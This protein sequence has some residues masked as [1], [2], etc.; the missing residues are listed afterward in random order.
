MAV[1]IK[2]YNQIL[3]EMI[4][5]IIADT[6]LNDVNAG[7]TLLTLMEAAAQVDFENN[8]SI[9]N[10]L[11]LL[12]IDAIS[13]N[14][15]DARAADFGLFRTP[16]QKATGFIDISDS[17]ITKI[18][19]G[20]YQVKPA[21]IAGST[22]LF[23]NDASQWAA[24]G[25][26]FIGRGTANF[27]GP[28]SYTSIVNSGSFFT[29][30]LASSLQKDH[31]ISET[32]ID[33][34]G[35][36]NRLISAGTI[37]QIPANNLNPVI[38]Y[39][40]VR[41]AIIPAGE[42]IV[43]DVEIV[44]I[45]AG[46][47]SNAGINTIVKF[48][49]VPFSGAT[50][51]NTTAL[52]NGTDVETDED[53]R[54]RVKSYSN[55][56]ARG[57]EAA[58][59]AAVIG[60]SDPDDGKQVAS[61]VITEP[62]KIGDPSILYIDDGGGFEPSFSG[63]SVD[64]LLNSANG[65]EE[66]LQL[67][68]FP[69]PRPQVLNT[70]DGPYELIDQMELRV[71]VDGVEEGII[72]TNDQF[73]NISAATLAETTIAINSQSTTFKATF[74]ENSN[75]ILL[76]PLDHAAETIQV[77]PIKTT[78]DPNLFANT[79]LKFPT[80]EFSYIR[81]YQNS[82]LL[83]EKERSATLLTNTYATW[84]IIADGHLIISV[85]NTPA[86]NRIFTEADFGGAPFAALT[87]DDWVSVINQKFAGLTAVSTSSGRVQLTSNKEGSDS[88]L[89]ILGG[90]LFD[91]LFA[92]QETISSGKNS[93]FE[94][95]RQNG[96]I[97]ILTDIKLGDSITAGIEDAKG[98]VFSTSTPTGSYNV[99]T[100]TNGRPARLVLSADSDKTTIRVG[101]GLAIGNVITVTDEGNNIMRLTSD[102]AASFAAIIPEDNLFIA[103]RGTTSSWINTANTGLFEVIS[104]GGHT[105]PGVDTYVEVKNINIIPGVHI[106][107][108]SEDIQAFRTSTYP[109]IWEGSFVST[110]AAVQIQELVDSFN[111][112]LVNI[113]TSIFKTSSMKTTSTTENDGSIS[114]AAG[115]GNALALY[116][117]LNNQDGTLGFVANRTSNKDFVSFFKRTPPTATNAEGITGKSVWLDRVQY[118]DIKG[119]F[120]D[121]AIP[122]TEGV[123]TYSEELESTGILT[124]NNLNYDDIVNYIAGANKGH[125]RS[126]R[127]Y[128]AGDKVGTQYA[129]PT[130]IMNTTV[131]DGFNLMRPTSLSPEDSIVFILDQDS[132]A[133]T[134]DVKISRTG[135]INSDF[136][137]TTF[138]FSANDADNEPG[139]TFG[140]LQ[141][142]GKGSNNT[143]FRDYSMWFR[144]RNWYISGGAGN[145]G[146][147]FMTRAVEYGPHGENIRFQIEYPVLPNTPNTIT[148]DNNPD[149][150]LVTYKFGSDVQRPIGLT[151]GNTF[152]V[153]SLGNDIF[154]YTFNNFPAFATVAVNDILSI[155]ST[156][157]VSANNSGQFSILAVSDLTKTIDIYN[158]NGVVTPIGNPEVTTVD[159]IADIV[160]TPT[161]ST[162]SNITAAAGLDGKYFII[163]DIAGSVAVYYN[164][165]TPNPGASILGVNRV[166]EVT[167]T[168]AEAANTVASLTSGL[169]TADSEF[170]SIAALTSITIT[171]TDNG[172][173]SIAADGSTATGFTFSGTSGTNDI[174]ID[175]TY[176]I[177]QDEN[178]SVAFWYDLSGTTPEPLH[179][180]D[181]AIQI[182]TVNYGDTANAIATKTAVLIAADPEF[183][184]ATVASNQIT[185]TDANNGDRPAANAGTT[186]FIVAESIAGVDDTLETINTASLVNIFP[187][188][189]TSVVEIVN[190]ISE[191]P[192]LVA[193]EIDT[194]ND[195]VKAT[196]EDIYVPAGPTDFSASLAFGHNPDSL[197][198]ANS[199]I[200]LFDSMGWVKDFDNLNPQFTLKNQLILPGAA[201]AIYAMDTTPNSDGTIG[202]YFKLVPSTLDNILHHFTQ[203]ALSQLPIV[204]DVKIANNVRRV[205]V[206][207][208][209]LGSQGA[210][211]IIGGNANN[212]DY[213]IFGEAQITPG[214]ETGTDFLQVKTRA[215]PVSLTKGTLVKI[216]NSQ[217]AKR[218]S[219]LSS[220]DTIDVFKGSG[221]NAEYLW[222]PKDTK[223]SDLV[224]FTISDVSALHGRNSGIVWRWQHNDGGSFYDIS[225]LTLGTPGAPPSNEVAAGGISAPNLHIDIVETG[226][227]TD[228]Q[229]FKLTVDGLPTQADYFTFQ[230]AS[231][232]TFATWF[233]I[234]NGANPG[235]IPTGVTYSTAVNQIQIDILTTDSEDQI[236]SKIAATLNS[237][238]SFLNEFRG[239]QTEGANFDDIRPGDL[240]NAY[241]AL[242]S[243]W[244]SGNKAFAS[245][246]GNIAGFPIIAVD[247]V[248]R[249]I[250][251]VNPNGVAMT[252]EEPIGNGNIEITPTPIIKWNTRHAAKTEIVQAIKIGTTVTLTTVDQHKL[253]EGDSFIIKNNGLSQSTIVTSVVDNLTITFTDVSGK[254][255]NLYPGGSIIDSTKTVT[256]YKIES[257]GFNNLYRLAWSEGEEPLF[258]DCG[259]AIDDFVSIQGD[260]FG[261]NNSGIF[262]ILGV[263]NRSIIFENEIATEEL[264][265]YFPFNDTGALATWVSNLDVVT[266]L[267]GTFANVSIGDWV[268]KPEDSDSEYKQ[269][270]AFLDNNDDP[271]TAVD[272]TKLKLGSN[273]KGT[274]SDSLGISYNQ[275]TDVGK[276]KILQNM[277]DIQFYE[278]D[279][280][281]I[282][283]NVFIDNIAD[284][285]WFNSVNSGT[286]NILQFGTDGTTLRPFIRV[287][288]PA[289]QSQT[290]REIGVA[291]LGFFILEGINYIYE[292]IRQIEHTAIDNFNPDR[293]S[294]Y[295]TPATKADKMSIINGTSIVPIGKL[296]Y[297]TDVTTGIDGYTYYTGLLR[298]VQRIVD[299]FEP[300]SVT[301]PGRRAVG[302]VIEI[303]PPLIRRVS[304]SIEVTTNE[305]VNLNEIS[306]D[307]KT[308]IIN[309]VGS[310][311][312]GEDVILSEVI[313]AVMDI[314]G[315]AAVTFNTPAPST[316]RIS[317][318]DN[319]KAFIEP[320]DIGVA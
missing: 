44:A 11:E 90:S 139:I 303:L 120:T 59:L 1:E 92:N 21:P 51:S 35:T 264:N 173:L 263:D 114:T 52:T 316:E 117:L 254:P 47:A 213:S 40:I 3:G 256:R 231:G 163:N 152:T 167:L 142:W 197:S 162:V 211:E 219:R 229:N 272:A 58:I 133:K 141:V 23:V 233:N 314:T 96:N 65:D 244:N 105:N 26:L 111:D 112:N 37:V 185:I 138:S 236:V 17:T 19:T 221:D 248:N 122:G 82:T 13:D 116:D 267:A 54:E 310:L 286:F 29:I 278:G 67:A 5:K 192:I 237:N 227:A 298:T 125:Y 260:T 207:S 134:I 268:K 95:N 305:G 91:K 43:K 311:G 157:G 16:A 187:L 106:V 88:S 279:S 222:N 49:S 121:N 160:G 277:S 271:V 14:N 216:K 45:A 153:T 72:F 209:L 69:L 195:I 208:K 220:N 15:L 242:S 308:A 55:T 259:I 230:S 223:L 240:L 292:S 166:I 102:S 309:Y 98:A 282:S 319:E 39:R 247:A 302:G 109:Q 201:P 124:A 182:S 107:E 312:V 285:N 128:L 281:Q 89:Q 180:A 184:S 212:I 168:G 186:G 265:T 232:A 31:L 177:L 33:A 68:N 181:R 172:T 63:Q 188:T 206:K 258:V 104:K 137:P 42:D 290:N 97:R 306:S 210:V 241:G 304:I 293:R 119:S 239:I 130:T 291:P 318:T 6:P 143:E 159:T 296:G 140:N 147:S 170:S 61:A 235:T 70:A 123:D 9:L 246:D 243:A 80:N 262:R 270:I 7:S 317:I 164:V 198:G 194:T 4:R 83:T 171:N 8:A 269:V 75:K 149:F 190:K 199:W 12:S 169:I 218:L 158:P 135:Q 108:A 77:S 228:L 136:P 38:E 50:V 275:N 273:Y 60:V 86:Q 27:E 200:R 266:G 284:S 234:I 46:S 238:I 178:G 289:G 79:I 250:D 2:S 257:L 251:V 283:D 165:G 225:D 56:L 204:A 226:T 25:E 300:E 100:D 74:T 24:T 62:P 48:S 36:S 146:G 126:V 93:D 175:S 154:R 81:L 145:G 287:E 280:V 156:S 28:I 252:S 66:F 176:F 189:G 295:M 18:S 10:V 85:D 161:V 131:G 301:F 76:F 193:T 148:H 101:V 255:D 30:N 276:G 315:V 191:S 78:D 118:T 155:Q 129:L 249:W 87:I 94:L 57:T 313:V 174:S 84:N 179:G 294:I 132:V 245:G 64:I 205:Q 203:K 288:N 274:T 215:F 150:S 41:D 73:L 253:R 299:G 202:E 32:V 113:D 103:S 22:Q 53:L 224:R 214:S 196:R 110:P 297:S 71:I 127:D 115:S 144:A 99:A 34:Q 261:S 217:P 151:D 20:L 183:A 320:S 307:I